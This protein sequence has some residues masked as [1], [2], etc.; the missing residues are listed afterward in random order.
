MAT[1]DI[2]TYASNKRQMCKALKSC[3]WNSAPI[4][5]IFVRDALI[6]MGTCWHISALFLVKHIKVSGNMDT[7]K[8]IEMFEGTMQW[9]SMSFSSQQVKYNSAW[10]YKTCIYTCQIF[11]HAMHK[12]ILTN[13]A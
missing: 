9:N 8:L 1:N 4:K 2:E 11:L 13:A 10:D 7:S 3:Q 5:Q 6:L 12:V